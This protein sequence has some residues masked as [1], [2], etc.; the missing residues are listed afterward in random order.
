MNRAKQSFRTYRACINGFLGSLACTIV[1][2]VLVE[3][4]ML[5]LWQSVGVVATLA[6]MQCVLHLIVFLHLGE[7][8]RPRWRAAALVFMALV[9]CIMVSG[10]VWIMYNLNYRMTPLSSQQINTYMNNQD[11]GL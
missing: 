10:S 9:V 7:E 6:C 11:G 3:Y 1:A 4:H 2:F 8:A 5:S